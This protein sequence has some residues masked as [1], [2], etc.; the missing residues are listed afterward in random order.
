MAVY[1]NREA[2]IPHTRQALIA[3]CLSENKLTV[4]EKKQFEEFCQILAA[5]Y[6]FK[7]HS[8]LENIKHNYTLFNPDRSG[9]VATQYDLASQKSM[10]ENLIQ[11]FTTIL[12]KANY[13]PLSKGVLRRALTDDSLFDLKTEV[14]FTDFEEMLCYCQGDIYK[15]I[16][17][18][19]FWRT[20]EKRVDIFERVVLLIKFKEEKHFRNKP[21]PQEK[22]DFKPGSVYIYL[23]KNLSKLDIEFI[24]P[25]VQMSMNW[26]DRLLFGIPA[27]GAS[28][29]LI[30]RV[31]PQLLLIAAVFFYVF[32][33]D[34][35]TSVIPVKEEE[36][37][38]ITPLLVTTL[39]LLVT[40]GGFAFKQYTRYKSKQIK[41]QK[42][43]T[44]TL[45]FRNIANNVGVFQYLIDAAEEEECKEIILVY[46][47]LLTSNTLLNSE[48]L[49]SSIE[50][51]MEERIGKKINFD[52]NE[53]IKNMEEIRG[54]IN[55]N[56]ED[57]PETTE[58]YL[59]KQDEHNYLQVLPLELAMKVID[60][61]WDNAFRYV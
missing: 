39:S 42:N 20:Q 23:Y 12:Q 59:L 15:N 5:Y 56:S 58:V 55:I 4:K 10:T 30:F 24:F 49:D 46:Y 50:L 28:I 48:Q 47:H 13:Y 33:G 8:Y 16:K 38:E 54:K 41:F 9:E 22:L 26:K 31:L 3:L 36:V 61:V 32:L 52:I 37:R 53:T 6:H 27:I 29:S 35:P 60:Y 11:D 7:F 45:F 14:D 21:T 18:K 34:I 43:I 2:F 57:N 17:I 40:L 51:W 25:N 19:K 44:E 1:Q